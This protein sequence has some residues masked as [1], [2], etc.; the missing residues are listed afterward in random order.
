MLLIKLETPKKP[1]RCSK[2]SLAW[3]K[4]RKIQEFSKEIRVRAPCKVG[5][6]F[7]F[8]LFNARKKAKGW[9]KA[10]GQAEKIQFSTSLPKS[11]N[12][13]KIPRVE[14]PNP[15]GCGISRV[16]K[17]SYQSQKESPHSGNFI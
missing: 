13:K 5:L 3:S 15:R 7:V 8:G 4:S 9:S 11:R 12:K 16:Q 10:Q 17:P 1:P 6:G 2:A 14:F